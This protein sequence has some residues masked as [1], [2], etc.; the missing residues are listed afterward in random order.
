MDIS[1]GGTTLQNLLR[2]VKTLDQPVSLPICFDL[3]HRE[4]PAKIIQIESDQRQ[5][6]ALVLVECQLFDEAK[7]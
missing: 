2:T 1:F 6:V 3:W 4:K 5:L 7:C